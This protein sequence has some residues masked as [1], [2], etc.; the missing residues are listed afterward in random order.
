MF[1]FPAALKSSSLPGY[2]RQYL[3]PASMILRQLYHCNKT[4]Y[5]SRFS[6]IG[7]IKTLSEIKGQQIPRIFRN[8]EKS[9]WEVISPR[10]V[11][12]IA[13]CELFCPR[14]MMTYDGV[15][16]YLF[17]RDTIPPILERE[18]KDAHFLPG[19]DNV[20]PQ[21]SAKGFVDSD[22]NSARRHL[23]GCSSEFVISYGHLENDKDAIFDHHH[24][25]LQQRRNLDARGDFNRDDD[26]T[27]PLL[28]VLCDPEFMRKNY[29]P[30]CLSNAHLFNL[31][32]NLNLN[33]KRLD[34]PTRQFAHAYSLTID[35]LG[36]KQDPERERKIREINRLRGNPANVRKE[37]LKNLRPAKVEIGILLLDAALQQGLSTKQQQMIQSQMMAYLEESQKFQDLKTQYEV[38]GP[39]GKQKQFVYASLCLCV[40][41]FVCLSICL[42]VCLSVCLSICLSLYIHISP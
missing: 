3:E 21:G 20:L 5:G 19:K 23:S 37:Y 41:L 32:G 42:S 31:V 10:D 26:A 17:P 7:K 35:R 15:K 9:V 30:I 34:K 40:F 1:P 39:L 18:F 16:D 12:F 28:R 38:D 33:A 4:K 36:E 27:T 29:R 24:C 11:K 8:N 22:E 13:G 2:L 14:G 25:I 6:E